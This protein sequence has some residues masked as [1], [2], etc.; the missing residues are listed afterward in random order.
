M[1]TFRLP[2]LF[3]PVAALVLATPAFAQLLSPDNPPGTAQQAP[4]QVQG[5]D[6]IVAVVNDGVV[7]QS[8]LNQ[9]VGT[10]LHQIQAQGGT[11]PP[12][13]VLQKQV[14]QRLILNKLEVQRARD[15]GLRVSDD[16]LDAAVAN[17]AQQN[18]MTVPQLQAA[19]QRDGVDYGA[20]REQLRDQ[21][22]IQELRQQVMQQ[23]AQV[24]DAEIDNL[25][26]S[27]AFKQ[28]EVHLARILIGLPEGATSAQIDAA[29]AKADK[30]E[31]ELKAGRDFSQLAVSSSDAPDALEGGDLGWRPVDELPG[32]IVQIINAMQ[33]G[34]VTAP[35]RDPSGFTIVKLIDR[36]TPDTRRIVTEYHARHLMIKPT[37]VLTP[38]Q[39]H[40]K[41]ETLYRDIVDGH[42]DFAALAKKDSDDP[43][44]ANAGGDMGWFM[45]DDW[46]SEV[47]KLLASMKPGEV[48]QPFQ[49][50][51]GSWHIIQ[52]LG[53]RQADKTEE[54]ERDQARQAIAMRKGEQAY[55]QFLRDLRSSAYVDILAPGLGE[56]ATASTGS[57]PSP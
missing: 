29:K 34:Q 48:S 28:G 44:T 25:I 6:R 46:G 57:P 55:E 10:I 18:K 2:A 35:L 36:R 4:Q 12:L 16:Q 15:N 43:T 14:L 54:L 39:A 22:L 47:G 49:S 40:G 31:D 30:I 8:E 1:N 56:D 53:T 5:L 45:Q 21:L 52:L 23:A 24:S 33:P 9:T 17:V 38:E 3:A 11:P 19:M 50:P 20:F 26:S 37:A 42:Q 51:D 13:D 41:I 32:P 27:P 7:L